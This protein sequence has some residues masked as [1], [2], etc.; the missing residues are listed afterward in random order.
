MGSGFRK[1]SADPI[2]HDCTPLLAR[3]GHERAHTHTYVRP[4]A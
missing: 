3:R 4:H 1:G 2:A